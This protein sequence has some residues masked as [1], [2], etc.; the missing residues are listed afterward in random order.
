MQTKD[1]GT[2]C[3]ADKKS[4][5]WSFL[6][7][8][9]TEMFFRCSTYN[10]LASGVCGARTD[11][12]HHVAPWVYAI[13][14]I[15]I[16]AGELAQKFQAE[17]SGSNVIIGVIATLVGMF[18]MHKKERDAERDKRVQYWQEQVLYSPLILFLRLPWPI[19][20]LR[21]RYA[22]TS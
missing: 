7:W 9:C 19:Y 13:V 15:G 21:M 14:G 5:S 12:P 2:A 18:F 11:T 8:N 10:C 17:V 1:I 16:M 4:V 22:R 3:D 20:V 6:H